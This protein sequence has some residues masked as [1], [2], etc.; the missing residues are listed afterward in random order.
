MTDS[1]RSLLRA[2]DGH[3]HG[4][5][6]MVELF[7]DLVFVFAVTQLSHTLLDQLTVAGAL[8]TLLLFFAVWWVWI[9]TS[10]C[11][12][13]LDPEKSPVRIMLFAL[14]LAGVLLSSS[15]PEAFGEKGMVFAG[16][17]AS[18]QVGRTLFMVHALR[19]QRP[20][21]FRN[22]CR[23]FVWLLVSAGFWLGGGLADGE[24]RLGLWI[25]ALLIE[26]VGP[27]VYFWVPGLGRSATT[28]WNV[29]GGHLAERC[30]LFV[31]IA[32]GESILVTGTTFA[33]LPFN[34]TTIGS[35]VVAFL[36]TVAMWWI[37]FDTGAVRASQRIVHSS[38]PGRQARTVYT[39]VHLLIVGG[40][41]V[42]AVADELVLLHPG[43]ADH[44]G[45]AT[46]LGG[47]ML[48]LLGN[49]LFKWLT[50]D[51]RGPPLSHLF[52]LALLA[53]LTPVGLSHALSALSLGA[54]TTT[55]LMLVAAWET[56]ALRR[57]AA[58]RPGTT[59]P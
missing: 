28:D 35:F 10:W 57:P 29:D 19:H 49:A 6:T 3:D 47:P 39:Y 16:A 4:R 42:C 50:N 41:I 14:M 18:M 44:A 8:H 54:A 58:A 27:V 25:A 43:Y 5:V 59:T 34:A 26:Y 53:L 7:F 51:R 30:G 46:I 15:L 22:F 31:I 11:T 2:R 56:A 21:L 38:D 55:I 1:A 20:E 9:Y 23:V 37:Y 40:I 13:W 48:Y 52:G 24:T 36:G 17:Y 32:L 12:N 33:G 45:L